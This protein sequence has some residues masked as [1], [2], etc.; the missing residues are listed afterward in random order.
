[1]RLATHRSFAVLSVTSVALLLAAAVQTPAAQNAKGLNEQ[2]V[3]QLLEAAC[4]A[5][6]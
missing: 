4:P 2:E 1:M 6:E 5:R 3:V